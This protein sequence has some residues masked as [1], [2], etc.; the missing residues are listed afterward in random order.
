MLLPCNGIDHISH[1]SMKK[2]NNDNYINPENLF[3]RGTNF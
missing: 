1:V 2:A 3:N